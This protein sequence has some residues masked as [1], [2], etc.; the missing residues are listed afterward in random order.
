MVFRVQLSTSGSAKSE[1]D[2][3]FAAV[4]PVQRV[5]EGK[6]YKYYSKGFNSEKEALQLLGVA[7]KNGFPDAFL[8]AFRGSL[9]ISVA[10]ARAQTTP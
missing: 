10:D 1:T 6:L 5:L 3:V 7:K 9:K 8:V 4:Q 2:P